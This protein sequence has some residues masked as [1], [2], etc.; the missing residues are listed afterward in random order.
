MCRRRVAEGP[1]AAGRSAGEGIPRRHSA[2]RARGDNGPAPVL[3]VFVALRAA[4]VL[5][6]TLSAA[7]KFGAL[8]LTGWRSRHRRLARRSLE[9]LA[10]R[11]PCAL[12]VR[13]ILVGMLHRGH[14]AGETRSTSRGGTCLHRV[15]RDLSAHLPRVVRS[16][17]RAGPAPRHGSSGGLP[18]RSHDHCLPPSV[19]PRGYHPWRVGWRG[20]WSLGADAVGAVCNTAPRGAAKRNRLGRHRPDLRRRLSGKRRTGAEPEAAREPSVASGAGS[21]RSVASAGLLCWGMTWD[22][23]SRK[24]AEEADCF[25]EFSVGSRPSYFRIGVEGRVEPLQAPAPDGE[26]DPAPFRWFSSRSIGSSPH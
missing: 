12:P 25:I 24:N 18:G 13:G 14:A 2:A 1:P 21:L 23:R 20:F 17:P 9:H 10:H 11:R 8:L 3:A 26:A 22:L 15:A 19:W 16:P 7:R 6:E 5:G 4:I